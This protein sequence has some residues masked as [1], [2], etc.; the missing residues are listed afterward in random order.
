MKEDAGDLSAEIERSVAR[1][2][3]MLRAAEASLADG[4]VES[5]ASRAYCSAFHAIQALLKSIGQTHS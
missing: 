2:E 4:F 1:S 3:R 5:A